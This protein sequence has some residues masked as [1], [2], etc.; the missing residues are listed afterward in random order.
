MAGRNKLDPFGVQLENGAPARKRT[1]R[2]MIKH[3]SCVLK[4]CEEC[5]IGK[6]RLKS[7][8]IGPFLSGHLK[9][10]IFGVELC[11][12]VSKSMMICMLAVRR[13]F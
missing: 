3:A 10:C 7:R 2:R 11:N 13:F 6:K 8:I 5:T 4:M 12:V 9:K 1:R